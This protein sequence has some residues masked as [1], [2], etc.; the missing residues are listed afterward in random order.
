[1]QGYDRLL[2][3]AMRPEFLEDTVVN[4]KAFVDGIEDTVVIHA[5]QVPC[6]LKIG[7]L[8][9]LYG[10]AELQGKRKR[11][12]HEVAVSHLSEPGQQVVHVEEEDGMAQ[13]RQCAK[14]EGDRFRVT[15][16]LSQVVSNVFKPSEKPEVR[17]GRPVLVVP[18]AHGR[19]SN[20]DEHGHFIEDEV[21]LVKGKQKVRKAKTSAGNLLLSWRKLRDQGDEES[22]AFFR[23]IEVMQQPSAFCDGVIIAWIA[24]LRR[25]EGY[26]QVISVRDMFVG[27]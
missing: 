27:A 24:E 19:L 12:R 20:I 3:E 16:E 14:G 13:V 10:N 2:W 22:R 25:K 6:W 26:T 11:K 8:R 1:M 23:D 5:D 18:G 21:F 9:Q 7:S 17:H 15:L 4:P